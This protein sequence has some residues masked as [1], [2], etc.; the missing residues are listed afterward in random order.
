[1]KVKDFIFIP[2]VLFVV[3]R[4]FLTL[5]AFFATKFIPDFGSRFPYYNERL[6]E[7]G[8]PDYIWSFGNFDGVHYVGIAKDAY[9]YQFTQAFFPLYPLLVGLFSRL[10]TIGILASSLIISNLIFVL[11]LIVFYKLILE[12]FDKKTAIWAL[13]FLLSFPT[14]FY[15]GSVYTESLFLFLILLTFYLSAK[16]HILLSAICGYFSSLTRLVGIFLSITAVKGKKINS[17]QLLLPML[18]LA[19]YMAYLQLKFDN[20]LY[21]LTS[22]SAFGQERSTTGIVLL[23]QVVFRWIKQ[24]L[25]TDGLVLFNSS[26]E[27]AS[28]TL[29]LILLFIGGK[30]LNKQW[31]IF[32]F[33]AVLIPTLTGSLASMP[34]YI[35]VAFPMFI[36]LANI[37]NLYLKSIVLLVFTGLLTICTSLFTRGY[38]IA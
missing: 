11:A 12:E 27:L 8:L 37:K 9:A 6:V 36:V 24:I 28:L 4:L 17:I 18:G 15:F 2:V 1:M 5:V 26:L 32:S 7:S 3:W 31:I 38:W 29:C 33:L 14:S 30:K 22:Q 21:F 23:P 13:L 10:T 34:R 35:L 25:T 20:A 16:N 19:T